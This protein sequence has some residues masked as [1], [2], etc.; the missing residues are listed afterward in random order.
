MGSGLVFCCQSHLLIPTCTHYKGQI[1]YPIFH[2]SY[3]TPQFVF[4]KKAEKLQKE[5]HV[6]PKTNR[7]LK[8]NCIPHIVG[9]MDN[10]IVTLGA[11]P[12]VLS[13]T[14]NNSDL[15]QMGIVMQ[16]GYGFLLGLD[17]ILL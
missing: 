12:L 7:L 8:N 16:S 10:F 2:P 15:L 3:W 14:N 4:E 17:N 6:V 9:S 11:I 5:V 1:W 13:W